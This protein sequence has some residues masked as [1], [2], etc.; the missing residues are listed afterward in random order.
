[1]LILRIKPLHP[2]SLIPLFVFAV[3]VAIVRYFWWAYV[4]GWR[5]PLG[6]S[7]IFIV[8]IPFI[9]LMFT[10]FIA[11]MFLVFWSIYKTMN[12]IPPIF[13]IICVG[14][15]FYMPLPQ[16]PDTPEKRHFLQY[17]ADYEAIIS[18]AKTDAL[19]LHDDCR[20][21]DGYKIPQSLYH[22]SHDGCVI[23]NLDMRGISIAFYPIE[24]VYHFV[25]YTEIETRYPCSS[26][27]RPIDTYVEQKIEPHWY[28]CEEDWN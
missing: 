27:N 15:A 12:F 22:I 20:R 1:M 13:L 10:F 2:Q 25:L 4:I 3:I 6:I 11:M 18:L 21:L 14:I 8:G 26:V 17:R 7:G 9:I 28:V 24:E 23:I 16:P 5:G 19:V